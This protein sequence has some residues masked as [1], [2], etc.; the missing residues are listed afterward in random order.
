MM[1]KLDMIDMTDLER[2]NGLNWFRM[3]FSRLISAFVRWKGPIRLQCGILLSK[4]Y[5]GFH[6]FRFDDTRTQLLQFS[7]SIFLEN[8]LSF[9]IVYSRISSIWMHSEKKALYA[10]VQAIAPQI[11]FQNL[12]KAENRIFFSTK[13]PSNPKYS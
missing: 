13:I 9:G 10:L 8:K 6:L 5:S 11:V 7:T 1:L 3:T 2:Y 4:I 12:S